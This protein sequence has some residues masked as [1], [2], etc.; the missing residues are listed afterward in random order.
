ME[1]RV[2][3]KAGAPVFHGYRTKEIAQ[4]QAIYESF[5]CELPHGHVGQLELCEG[6]TVRSVKVNLRRTSTRLGIKISVW[7]I[8]NGP[9]Y[10]KFAR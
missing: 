5:L 3:T 1:F 4:R 8:G 6:E 9:V 7:G 10:F 2:L